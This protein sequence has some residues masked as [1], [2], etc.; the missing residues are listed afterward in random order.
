MGNV[1][2]SIFEAGTKL[3]TK[4]QD[5]SASAAKKN[6]CFERS[7]SATLCSWNTPSVAQVTP[8]LS[9]NIGGPLHFLVVSFV[10]SA[11]DDVTACHNISM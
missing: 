1:G 4:S 7:S 11:T 3:G 2:S 5:V 8:A 10:L 9:S 6:L